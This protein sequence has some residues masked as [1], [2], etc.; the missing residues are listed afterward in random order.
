[1]DRRVDAGAVRYLTARALLTRGVP[2]PSHA[3]ERYRPDSCD[4]RPS[5]YRLPAH[6]R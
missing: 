6:G 2:Y 1:M 5:A 3:F 4:S